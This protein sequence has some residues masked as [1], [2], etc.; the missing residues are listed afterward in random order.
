MGS[1]LNG[2]FRSAVVL[3]SPDK[4]IRIFRGSS[5]TRPLRTPATAAH[6]RIHPKTIEAAAI[7]SGLSFSLLRDLI[8]VTV[9][10]VRIPPAQR[11]KESVKV[12]TRSCREA[13]GGR[14]CVLRADWQCRAC[15]KLR[16]S[17]E[18]GYLCPG[19]IFRAFGDLPRP[20]LLL[21]YVF[22]RLETL[23]RLAL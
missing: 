14:F 22:T 7:T 9:L 10:S 3:V 13:N 19:I 4:E 16:Y 21:P 23:Q 11:V 12:C 1:H 17:S 18:G 5:Q 15:T 20:N 2:A 8:P 6:T